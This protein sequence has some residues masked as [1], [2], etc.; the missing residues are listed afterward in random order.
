MYCDRCSMFFSMTTHQVSPLDLNH[1]PKQTATPN[2]RPVPLEY[3]PTRSMKGGTS[4][5]EDNGGSDNELIPGFFNDFL[6]ESDDPSQM[7]PQTNWPALP[8]SSVSQLGSGSGSPSQ[9][10]ASQLDPLN[11]CISAS[12]RTG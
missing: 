9:I 1:S 4:E 7:Q 5:N 3:W 11:S 6:E 12:G 8:H 2:G 10:P